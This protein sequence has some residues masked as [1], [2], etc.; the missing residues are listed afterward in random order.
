MAGRLV[1][2]L[3]AGVNRRNGAG[4][5]LPTLGELA[6]HLAER[7][8]MPPGHEPDLA[9]VSQ[10]V[11]LTKGVGPLYDELHALLDH[12]LEPGPAHHLVAATAA[13]AARAGL[14]RQLDRHV[15]LRPRPGA[16]LR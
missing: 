12:D 9:R 7:F 14:P 3:G 4:G 5:E 8:D 11:A 1:T 2:V 6:A 13:I 16:G 10:Y 15:E